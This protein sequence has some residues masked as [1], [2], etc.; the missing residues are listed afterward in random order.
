MT[1]RLAWVCWSALLTLFILVAVTLEYY[2]RGYWLAVGMTVD[3]IMGLAVLVAMIDFI[4]K[5]FNAEAYFVARQEKIRKQKE[6]Y[7]A[8]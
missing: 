8:K 7:S 6:W 2:V 4:D 3:I 5:K 1:H